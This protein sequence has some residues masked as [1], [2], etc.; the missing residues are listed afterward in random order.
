MHIFV[1]CDDLVNAVFDLA[2]SL[3]RLQ[4]S[5]EEMALFSAAVLLAPGETLT[6]VCYQ[7]RDSFPEAKVYKA[8]FIGFPEKFA[9]KNKNP[10]ALCLCGAQIGRG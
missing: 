7:F 8:A 5:E 6:H 3:S 10:S 4:L 2:K 9:H 1:G